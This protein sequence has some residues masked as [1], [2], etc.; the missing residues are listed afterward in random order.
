MPIY[1]GADVASCVVA[2]QILAATM[3]H[4]DYA[5]GATVISAG[6]TLGHLVSAAE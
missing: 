6:E 3:T 4:H 1:R 5:T 2:L